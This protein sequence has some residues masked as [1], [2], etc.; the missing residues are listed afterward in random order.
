METHIFVAI[1]LKM[2]IV[3]ESAKIDQRRGWVLEY[4]GSY[5]DQ[6][7]Y[8]CTSTN[9]SRPEKS[10]LILKLLPASQ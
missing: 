3:V 6:T 5:I 2:T 9:W 10:S 4:Q 1:D 8:V 7:H